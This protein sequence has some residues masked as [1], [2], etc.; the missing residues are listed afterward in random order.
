MKKIIFAI[1]IILAVC[2][3][4]ISVIG[5]NYDFMT[6]RERII[7]SP[8]HRTSYLDLGFR[9]HLIPVA[10][11]AYPGFYHKF[12]PA[13]IALH[14]EQPH[15]SANIPGAS[16]SQPLYQWQLVNSVFDIYDQSG[17]IYEERLRRAKLGIEHH[18]LPIFHH[19]Y[20]CMPEALHEAP[21]RQVEIAGE[22]AHRFLS[23]NEWDIVPMSYQQM[24][25]MSNMYDDVVEMSPQDDALLT[26]LSEQSTK[27]NMN[28]MEDYETM[29]MEE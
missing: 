1:T 13:A 25:E 11:H 21:Y 19:L 10:P 8:A 7:E 14:R 24:L 3:S 29:M 4:S 17:C 16:Y 27:D 6:A 2:L 18:D 26:A 23:G 9:P 15:I 28:E 22:R 5:A 12:Y 20:R